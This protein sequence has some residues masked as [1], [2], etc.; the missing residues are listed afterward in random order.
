MCSTFGDYTLLVCGV[1]TLILMWL[2]GT[3]CP[4]FVAY[5]TCLFAISNNSQ[6]AD[7]TL[8]WLKHLLWYL[9]LS[10]FSN[11]N[12]SADLV[13]LRQRYLQRIVWTNYI[14]LFAISN[15]YQ[16]ADLA[17]LWLKHLCTLGCLVLSTI[18]N[19]NLSADMALLRQ[20]YLQK[21]VWT[22]FFLGGGM[23]RGCLPT[24][25]E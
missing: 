25:H 14:G 17:L 9:W 20:R 10:T 21:I 18:S 23:C 12:L 24:Q 13:L 5:Y 19:N 22:I 2:F 8:L 16:F 7:L 11:N 3:V 6:F 15:N 1:N 4:W